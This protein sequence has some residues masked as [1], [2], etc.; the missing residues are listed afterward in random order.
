MLSVCGQSHGQ[1][2]K[3]LSGSMDGVPDEY[4]QFKCFAEISF[5][6]GNFS[7]AVG[8]YEKALS[9]KIFESPNYDLRLEKGYSQCLAG[10]VDLGLQSISS[11]VLMAK[12]DLGHL[13]CP[14]NEEELAKVIQFEHMHLACEGSA[15]N[16]AEHGRVSLESRLILAGEYIE[17]CKEFDKKD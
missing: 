16:L 11:F 14:E 3:D 7:E 12:A 17:L 9:L 13:T 1:T 6:R 5:A 15:S 10:K 4:H 2:C 8:N